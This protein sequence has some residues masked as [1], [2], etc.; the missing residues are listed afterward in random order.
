MAARY[1]LLQ[2]QQLRLTALSLLHCDPHSLHY[3]A[4]T[5]ESARDETELRRGRHTPRKKKVL[6]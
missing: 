4:R 2:L 5:V 1:W 3:W 6:L